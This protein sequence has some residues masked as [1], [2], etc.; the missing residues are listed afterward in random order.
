M[1]DCAQEIALLQELLQVRLPHS[2]VELLTSRGGTAAPFPFAGLPLSLEPDSAWGATEIL[3]ASRPDLERNLVVLALANNQAL[4]IRSDNQNDGPLV[5][6]DLDSDRPS[7][8]VADSL[9]EFIR[10]K[11]T[12][13]KAPDQGELKGQAANEWFSRG[14]DRLQYHVN[15]LAFTYDHK[16][17]GRLPRNHLWRPYRFCVQDVILGI[18]VLRHNRRFNRLDVDVFLTASIPE[19]EADS[20]CRALCLILLSEAHKCGGSMEIHFTPH[21]EGGGVPSELA[22][23]A[24]D[25]GVTLEHV[26]QGGLTPQEAGR[27]YLAL[28]GFRAEV[29]DDI[30][31]FGNE[32]K[33]SVPGICY[34][35]NHGVWSVEELEVVIYTSQAPDRVLSGGAWPEA[36]HLFQDDLCCTRNA[37]MSG[38]LDRQILHREHLAE[39]DRVIELEDDHQPVQIFFEPGTGL[40]C[41]GLK[42]GETAVPIPWLANDPGFDAI[43]GGE[44]LQ[45]LLRARES[46]DLKQRMGDDLEA[47]LALAGEEKRRKTCIMVPADFKV[48]D[49]KEVSKRASQGGVGILLCPEFLN[50]LN[51]ESMKRL[52][53]VRVIR[54]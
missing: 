41:Y 25:L 47:A 50:G 30:L 6:V 43:Q 27:L 49:L 13:P 31:S 23:L 7:E 4:C 44:T 26:R 48:L 32:G 2:H 35:V 38:Y 11:G 51:Q 42:K 19:Y 18:T 46:A 39:G 54:Q 36:Y 16:K 28:T 5:A 14:L 20:G 17:G 37:V 8:G 1:D 34:A 29:R 40:K 10:G 12:W 53:S 24:K 52:E 33:V 15:R 21:V 22:A 9:A 3:R 45:V